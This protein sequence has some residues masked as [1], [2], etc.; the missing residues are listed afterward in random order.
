ML[1]LQ[2]R[3]EPVGN[4][5]DGDNDNDNDEFTSVETEAVDGWVA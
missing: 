1:S 3:D 2:N 4:A 5:E